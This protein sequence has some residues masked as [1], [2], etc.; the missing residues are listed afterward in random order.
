MAVELKSVSFR[1]GDVDL[2]ADLRL[3]ADFEADQKYA[4]LVI[5]TPGSSVKG[6]IGANYG[7][8][9]ADRG[10]VTLVFDPS[11]QG[12]SG[13]EPR[14]LEDP[15]TRVEDIR[16][17]VDYLTTLDYVDEGSI[18]VLGI[19]A[20]GGYAVN[21]AMTEHRIRAVGTVVAVNLG[22][23]FRQASDSADAVV[24]TLEAVG[25]ARTGEA[26]AGEPVRNPWIPDTL[27]GAKAAGITDRD[28]L[29]AVEFYRTPRGFDEHSTNRRH[30]RSDA[31]ILGFDAFHLIEELLTQPIQVI[32][33]GRR[34]STGSFEDGELLWE[35][36]RNKE[37]LFVID[38]AGHYDL[39]DRPE[40]VDHAIDR[41]DGFFSKWLGPVSPAT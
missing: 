7:S 9:M 29:E 40:Y 28:V 20:G 30:Y 8:R 27:E 5:T 41:L 15:A 26:R 11:H 12:Q 1:N 16:C 32:V 17:A 39:Y 35:R 31:L 38:G 36:A 4:A 19:C 6:Q 21:A 10:F 13:G 37:E 34:G 18:G 2:V 33:G 24:Q 25:A 14:D 23:A 22:R 3:P